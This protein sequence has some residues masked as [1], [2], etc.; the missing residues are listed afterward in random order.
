M[1]GHNLYT[2]KKSIQCEMAPL[3]FE[4]ILKKL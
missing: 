2:D 4:I 1:C 3:I